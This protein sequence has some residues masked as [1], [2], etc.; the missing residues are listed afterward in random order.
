MVVVVGDT[1]NPL[2]VPAS[3]PPQDEVYQRIT[4]PVPPPPPFKVSVLLCP[5]QIVV[6]DAVA[7]VGLAAGWFTV[8]VTVAQVVLFEQGD[9]VVYLP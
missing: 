2:P 6:E 9:E 3:V 5:L 7:D 1:L 4:W 8:T